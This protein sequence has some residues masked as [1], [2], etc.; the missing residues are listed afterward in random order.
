MP[1]DFDVVI[2]GGGLTGAATAALLAT[3]PPT[4]ALRVA[5]LEPAPVLAPPA[6]APLNLRVS[7]VSRSS[8]QLLRHCRAWDAV[9]ARGAAACQRMVIWDEHGSAGGA[10]GL[11]FAAADCGEPD[12]GHLVENR[13]M[14]AA[15]LARATAAG[16]VVL[17]TRVE[18]LTPAATAIAIG[19]SDGRRLEAAL[20]V[21]A[22]GSD[23]SVR[24][25]A[26]IATTGHDYGQHAVV[27]HLQAERPHRDTAWQRFLG[28]GPLALL[29]LADGRVSLVWSTAP[30]E[31]AALLAA[32]PPEFGRR[33]TVAAAGVLGRLELT[34]AR[35]AFP[36]RLR[37]AVR[38]AGHRVVLVG[39][40][41][42]QVHPLA[43]LGV[44]LGFLD[45]GALADVLGEAVAGGG[46]PGEPRARR[47]YERWRRAASGP[48]ITALDGIWRLFAADAPV[49][50]W[51]RR[52]GLDLVDASSSA[53]RLLVRRALGLAGAVPRSLQPPAGG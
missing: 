40:A 19:T 42:Q 31:A 37:R 35:A 17:P 50:A 3:W 25:L 52:R 27:A 14:Q 2:A 41:A 53:K 4:A 44:N 6:G 18:S 24:R 15:L 33:V 20:L 16:A 22:D 51:L 47:R 29:P 49:P 39:D 30:A 7:L 46:D 8:E 26:G 38:H 48:M 36:L 21:G 23:S 13:A 9:V 1:R 45:V 34:T 5:V 43:G 28:T 32:E 10:G 11:V 12:L